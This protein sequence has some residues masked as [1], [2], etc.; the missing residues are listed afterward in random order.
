MGHV[1]VDTWGFVAQADRR[2]AW[3]SAATEALTELSAGG[4]GLA[5]STDVIDE[6]VTA[7]SA[8]L[9]GKAAVQFLGDLEAMALGEE[10]AVIAITEARRAAGAK[11]FRRLAPEVPRLSL[12]DCTSFAVMHELGLTLALTGDQHFT[13]AGKG[14][15]PLFLRSGQSLEFRPPR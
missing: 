6:A 4:W 2:D 15:R 5:T 7:V 12:T 11:V 9:G 10:L 8:L 1:F 13:R 14:I 3:H